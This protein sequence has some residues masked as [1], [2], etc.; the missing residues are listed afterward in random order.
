[1]TK[2]IAL[3]YKRGDLPELDSNK[4]LGQYGPA[5]TF[6][7]QGKVVAC[8]GATIFW[9]GCAE[10]W[11]TPGPEMKKYGY[12][13]VIQTRRVLDMFQRAYGLRRLQADVVADNE[14]NRRFIEHYGFKAEG[15][16]R[17]YDALGRDCIRYSRIME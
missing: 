10:V 6:W 17:K 15:L 7:D 13:L 8:A 1:M 2:I 5:F 11:L 3:P 12:S 14:V 9:K 4:T 16:M